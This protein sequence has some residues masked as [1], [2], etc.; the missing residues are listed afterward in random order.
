MLLRLP[1][2]SK[3]VVIHIPYRV[4][5]VKHTHTVYKIIPHY[6]EEKSD[7]VEEDEKYENY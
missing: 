3:K 4:N 6:H 5:N 7:D 2:E 1:A